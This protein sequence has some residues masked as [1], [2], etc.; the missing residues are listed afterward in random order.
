MAPFGPVGSLVAV[1]LA[2]SIFTEVITNNAA[3]ALMFPIALS[4]AERSVAAGHATDP[5]PFLIAVA[6]G[7]SASFATPIGY[8]TNLIVQ[9]AGGYRFRDFLKVGAPMNLLALIVGVVAI[10]AWYGIG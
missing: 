8:Q 10:I 6:I 3:A 9:G 4:T 1:Y 5:I 7:A 2:T